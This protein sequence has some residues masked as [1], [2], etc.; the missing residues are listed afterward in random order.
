[1]GDELLDL[2]DVEIGTEIEN[3]VDEGLESNPDVKPDENKET[4]DGD[5]TTPITV[6][7]PP[8]DLTDETPATED[9][10]EVEIPESLNEA[11]REKEKEAFIAMR[12]ELSEYRKLKKAGVGPD[13]VTSQERLRELE[14]KEA[15]M[16][17]ASS[18][19]FKAAHMTPI[20]DLGKQILAVA[21]T[22]GFTAEIINQ[23]ST[24]AGKER[25]SF[26]KSNTDDPDAILEVLP[27]MQQ[28][29]T[30][31]ATA[32]EAIKAKREGF[33]QSTQAKQAEVAKQRDVMFSQALQGLADKHFLLKPSAKKPEWLTTI[34]ANARA[35]VEGKT[36]PEAVV[37]A[38]LKAQV[39]DHYLSMFT[40]ER[41][42]RLALQT[43]IDKLKGIRPR[44]GGG[45]SQDK[46][47]GSQDGGTGAKDIDSLVDLTIPG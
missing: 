24:L 47:G 46:S 11:G 5:Q 17:Y 28:L 45:G 9:E 26:L 16:D 23:A 31:K 41:Q 4:P 13:S 19:E 7:A 42:A 43:Q 25:L 34:T 3:L 35:L 18:S 37:E 30:M 32:Q 20:M 12:T 33:S 27:M 1:M 14:A 36:K 39:A 21:K 29:D 6:E 15:A 40:A 10:D 44:T 8:D 22:N 2:G 38:A